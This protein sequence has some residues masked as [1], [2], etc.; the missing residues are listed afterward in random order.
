M[1]TYEVVGGGGTKLHVVESGRENGRTILFIHGYSQSSLCW[2]RQM[3]SDL[4]NDHRL[5]AM[6]LRGHGLSDKPSEGYTDSK[7]W[8]DDVNAVIKTLRLD[9]PALCGW[10]YGSIVILDYLRHYGEDR[11]GGLDLVG[12]VTKLGTEAALAVLTQD[13]LSLVPG[14]FSEHTEESVKS[15]RAL[16]HLCVQKLTA[17]ELY[18]MLGAS[19][20]VPTYVRKALFSRTFDNDDLLPKIRKPVL[21][22]YG[23]ED[24]VV[25]ASAV[26]EHVAGLP[27]A[28]IHLVQGSGH[29]PF[30]DE[31][32]LYNQRLREFCASLGKQRRVEQRT[33]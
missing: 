12:A 30:W 20:S 22:T 4:A 26:E 25:K 27:H 1:K 10:S 23:T 29:A 9:Q 31:A 15:L 7:L 17:E 32:S 21:I 24:K 8:A 19:I 13:F 14:F 16:I 5:L 11:I 28:Q 33:L 3:N 6:D 18:L 2:S